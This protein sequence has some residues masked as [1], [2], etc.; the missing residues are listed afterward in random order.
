VVE[1]P[2][3]VEGFVPNSHLGLSGAKKPADTLKAGDTLSLKVI[4]F[5]QEN[6][7]ITLSA[8][9]HQ[10]AKESE[11]LDRYQSS[12]SNDQRTTLGDVIDFSSAKSKKD[13]KK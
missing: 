8:D 12:A 5:D 10:R 3:N 4:E 2:E 7:K 6:R 1:L 11:E 13:D 9:E